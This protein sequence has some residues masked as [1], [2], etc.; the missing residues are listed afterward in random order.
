[1]AEF[2]S[3]RIAVDVRTLAVSANMQRGIGTYTAHHLRAV[4]D[5][6]PHWQF[7]LSGASGAGDG[8]GKSSPIA[9]LLSRDNVRVLSSAELRPD[10]IDLFHIPDPTGL[11]PGFESPFPLIPDNVPSSTVFFD[12]IPLVLR[13]Y[14]IDHWSPLLKAAYFD[15]LDN[16]QRDTLLVLPISEATKNDLHKLRGVPR[17]RMSTIWAG[18][19]NAPRTGEPAQQEIDELK[20]SQGISRPYFLIV[21]A[22]DSHKNFPV[23]IE[24]FLKAGGSARYNLVVVGD[25]DS[26]PLKPIYMAQLRESRTDGVIFTGFVTRASLDLLYAGAEALV[27]PSAYEGFGFPVLEAMA[28]RCPVITTNASSIPEVGGEAPLY[29]AAGSSDA[30][31]AAMHQVS[32]SEVRHRMIA[33]GAKQAAKFSWDRTAQRTIASWEWWIQASKQSVHPAMSEEYVDRFAP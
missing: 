26:D 18:L 24:A 23:A 7:L 4:V 1:M 2:D 30:L 9:E 20:R 22:L 32:S 15:R 14:H 12:L 10:A 27:F 31:A 29:V 28:N 19:N 3:F 16:L 8:G 5:A 33:A 25:V 21:G 13:E 6:A 17:E 11:S